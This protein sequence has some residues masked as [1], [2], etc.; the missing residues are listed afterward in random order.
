MPTREAPRVRNEQAVLLWLAYEQD[1]RR[2]GGIPSGLPLVRRHHPSEGPDEFTMHEI[3]DQC[4]SFWQVR[5]LRASRGTMVRAAWRVMG[6]PDHRQTSERN[7]LRPEHLLGKVTCR[8]PE[9]CRFTVFKYS[10][11]PADLIAA[12]GSGWRS[13]P[14]G[15]KPEEASA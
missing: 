2:S 6:P 4:W 9:R 15:K 13:I 11:T 3:E 8:V 10:A 12:A 7:G 5:G 14:H 1:R